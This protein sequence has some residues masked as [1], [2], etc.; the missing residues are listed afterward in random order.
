MTRHC[1]TESFRTFVRLYSYSTHFYASAMPIYTFLDYS[2]MYQYRS[3]N[4]FEEKLFRT[5]RIG[6]FDHNPIIVTSISQ[7]EINLDE[8]FCF[9][10]IRKWIHFSLFL[11]AGKYQTL[12]I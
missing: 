7:F 1:N 8:R 11:L 9:R 3:L 4:K 5:L 2:F 12:S 10:L 6:N